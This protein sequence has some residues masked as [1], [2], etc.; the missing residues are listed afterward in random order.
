MS[1]D[2]YHIKRPLKSLEELEKEVLEA[3]KHL[4]IDTDKAVK[5]LDV[6]SGGDWFKQSADNFKNNNVTDLDTSLFKEDTKSARAI[7]DPSSKSYNV[8]IEYANGRRDVIRGISKV[9][10]NWIQSF[11]KNNSKLKSSEQDTI[12]RGRI[13]SSIQNNTIFKGRINQR[14]SNMRRLSS[15]NFIG[16][17]FKGR[18]H[19][20]SASARRS[21]RNVLNK[22]VL[23]PFNFINNAITKG[24]N[25]LLGSFSKLMAK[26]LLN[27]FVLG[28]LA[29]IV[30]VYLLIT[31]IPIY[32]VN[33]EENEFVDNPSNC[34]LENLCVRYEEWSALSVSIGNVYGVYF[35][36]N[37]AFALAMTLNTEFGLST[38]EEITR[39]QAN[40][41]SSEFG[42]NIIYSMLGP[43]MTRTEYFHR[44]WG[45]W[46]TGFK[47]LPTGY[48]QTRS[49]TVVEREWVEPVLL[50]EWY[51]VNS[52]DDIKY[53]S[54]QSTR[55]RNGFV[56]K[57][58]E[59]TIDGYWRFIDVPYW[60]ARKIIDSWWDISD[61]DVAT[62]SDGV[63]N[64]NKYT[65][66]YPINPKEDIP[67]CKDCKIVNVIT[68]AGHITRLVD[69]WTV[70]DIDE[71]EAW[72]FE[73]A[74]KGS[75]F[76]NEFGFSNLLNVS[77]DID[78]N[79]LSNYIDSLNVL[80]SD[81]DV[82][83]S[84]GNIFANY[85]WKNAKNGHNLSIGYSGELLDSFVVDFTNWQQTIQMLFQTGDFAV[86][87][88]VMFTNPVDQSTVITSRF[89][90]RYIG[91][92]WKFHYGVDFAPTSNFIPAN[93]LSVM[94]KGI[95]V[96]VYNQCS[97]NGYL[98]EKCGP[99]GETGA[100]NI[101]KVKYTV[102]DFSGNRVDL[103]IMYAHLVKDSML[104]KNGQEVNAGQIIAKLGNSGNSTGS[105]LHLGAYIIDSNGNK[106][107][108]NPEFMIR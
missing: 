97:N 26:F 32:T 82:S 99:I 11:T 24:L 3:N 91:G 5:N 96:D 39:N 55:C 30:I 63:M 62:I 50:N 2:P 41:N 33:G 73:N 83:I 86:P 45:N 87:L 57:Q 69:F 78:E 108:L 34:V 21:V 29:I 94:N 95:V 31:S 48:D 56:N 103:Y 51:C 75:E 10:E 93:I 81:P 36:V 40:F 43:M 61:V 49:Y 8:E 102:V 13:K 92:Q 65:Y 71:T 76:M 70:K 7:Y 44:T 9:D 79:K 20:V 15:N 66:S 67:D 22:S 101:I 77:N 60:D 4:K 74:P 47:S 85:F 17:L 25:N 1:K 98:G 28:G 6:F 58:I 35:N 106:G 84:I 14:I 42:E 89:G 90:M 80:S 104:V 46:D 27:P 16:R 88:N 38:D 59:E 12:F 100:G 52:I 54:S 72:L 105:H 18:I 68:D 23:K 64:S 19:S 53:K 37:D 107:Y